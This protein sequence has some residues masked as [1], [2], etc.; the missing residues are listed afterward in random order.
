M[1]GTAATPPGGNRWSKRVPAFG[2]YSRYMIGSHA[3]HIQIVLV[4]LVCIVL[5]VDISPW[6]GSVWAGAADKKVAGAI[7]AVLRFSAYRAFDIMA[8]VFPIA[9]VLGMLWAETVHSGSGQRLMIQITGRSHFR[10]ATPLVLVALAATLIQFALDNYVRPDAVIQLI[11]E[12]LGSYRSY[13]DRVPPERAVW[14]SLGDDILQARISKADPP[15]FEALTYYRFAKDHVRD[16]TVADAARPTAKGN[17]SFWT[18][19]NGNIWHFDAGRGRSIDALGTRYPGSPFEELQLELPIDPLWL[20]YRGIDPKYLPAKV[21]SRLAKSRGI[22]SD[23]PKYAAWLQLRYA[24]AF[25]PG[26]LG[27]LVAAVFYLLQDR[28]PLLVA[29]L[30]SLAL[31]YMGF[32]V[33]RL[34]TVIAEHAVLP[35]AVVAWALPALLAASSAVTFWRLARYDRAYPSGSSIAGE[36]A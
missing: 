24:Q 29:V 5:A 31:G 1:R 16:I 25:I 9:C 18:F 8:Q 23:Q 10:A 20:Q 26:M 21:L 32:A 17:A 6:V 11:G 15:T 12:R 19:L 22:P 30:A 35:P 4:M 7:A 33:M 3:W 13:V 34:M 2:S 28:R 14:L 36:A 27:L